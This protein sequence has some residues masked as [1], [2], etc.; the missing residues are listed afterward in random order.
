MNELGKVDSSV[1][2]HVHDRDGLLARRAEI[3]DHVLDE[4]GTLC[5]LAL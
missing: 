4:H 2:T 5:N 3:L 1:L